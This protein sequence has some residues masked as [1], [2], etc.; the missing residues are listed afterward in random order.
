MEKLYMSSPD[1]SS[2]E[3]Q[4]VVRAIRSGWIAPLGPDVDGFE[5]DIK[6]RIG[7]SHAVALSSGTAALH[8][9]LLGLGV[10]PGDIVVAST[11]TFVATANAIS[12]VGATP[13]FVDS[14]KSTGNMDPELL[15]QALE[16][17][18]RQGRRVAAVVPVDIFGKCVDYTT[19][20]GIAA[21]FGVPL[22]CDSAESL[23]ATHR[24]KPAGS[25]GAA[26]VFSFNGNK[27]MTT[28]GGGML[29]T[30]DGSLADKVRHLATQARVPV[31]HYEHVDIGYNYRMSNLLAALGRAQLTRLDSMMEKRRVIRER[32]RDFF[33]N[34]EGAQI[35]G[36]SCDAEDNCWLTS[37]VVDKDKAGWDSSE[38]IAALDKHG[39]ESRPLWKPM[40][41]QPVYSRSDGIYNGVAETLFST[42][43]TLP[44]G[45]NLT[46]G[47][48]ARVFGALSDFVEGSEFA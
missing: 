33:S 44:S 8:L 38:L 12:Y 36:G 20:S 46:D 34:V 17:L 47:Q 16:M 43:V 15:R 24:Q 22:L 5:E 48:L 26:A 40:H 1:I 25:F 10:K 11:M 39:I 30:S 9:G 35:F 27:I 19:I 18:Q 2:L 45:S 29:L 42:G 13:F 37:I 23:G 4:Y 3:E 41:L 32:Y 6:A 21:E 31:R 14:E 7:V 28:S